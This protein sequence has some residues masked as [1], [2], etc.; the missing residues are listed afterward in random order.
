L[1]LPSLVL[2]KLGG[3]AL[4]GFVP[5]RLAYWKGPELEIAFYPSDILIRGKTERSGWTHGLLA[6]AIVHGPGLQT[7]GAEAQ[8]IERQIRRIWR[9]YDENPIAH[10]RSTALLSRLSDIA[11]D[12]GAIHV[13]YDQWQVLYRQTLQLARALDGERQLLDQLTAS[14]E[15]TMQPDQPTTERPLASTS[16]GE[17]VGQLAKESTEL[18]KKEIALAQSELRRDLKREIKMAEGL[19]VAGVCA[20][21]LLNLLLVALVFALSDIMPGWTAALMVAGGV[22]LMGMAAALIGWSMRVKTPLEKTR[23]TLKEDARW[24]KERLA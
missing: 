15:T 12:L 18:V 6:E 21:T 3:N 23:K 16:T 4:R 24:T 5:D 19:T 20:L 10:V 1:A 11:T 8:D 9:V 7:F 2:Q 22:L 13:D 17:L 14:T